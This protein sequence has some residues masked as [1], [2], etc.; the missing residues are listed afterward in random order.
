MPYPS[1]EV[2]EVPIVP[3]D[4]A[5]DRHLGDRGIIDVRRRLIDMV[6]RAWS[7]ALTARPCPTPPPGENQ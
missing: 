2:F 4:H 5:G 3:W 6:H 7:E 1:L